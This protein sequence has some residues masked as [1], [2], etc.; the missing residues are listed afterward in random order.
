MASPWIEKI[1]ASGWNFFFMAEEV[2]AMFFGA[3]GPKKIENA[4]RRIL[5]KGTAATL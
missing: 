3:P 5:G 1:R 4:M 2:K